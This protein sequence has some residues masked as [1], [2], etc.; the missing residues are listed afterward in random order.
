MRYRPSGRA[1]TI[2]LWRA[3]AKPPLEVVVVTKN[4]KVANIAVWAKKD[5]SD[6]KWKQMELKEDGNYHVDIDVSALGYKTGKYYIHAY[7]I[8]EDGK[9]FILSEDTFDIN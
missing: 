2:A 3:K 9:Q 1:V 5:Q 8:D 4:I 7:I 6:L